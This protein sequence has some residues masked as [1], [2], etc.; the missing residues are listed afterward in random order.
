MKKEY[1]LKD[2][3][4]FN[5]VIK[6]GKKLKDKNYVVY[7]LPSFKLKVGISI[8]KKLGNAPFRNYQKRVIR[9]ICRDSIDYNMK[10]DIVIIGR[11][12]IKNISYEEKV[13]SLKLLIERIN[14]EKF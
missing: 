3:R 1:I 9:S 11:E 4:R 13:N 10:Y 5:E 8:G 14:N 6:M 7:F 2:K 12:N